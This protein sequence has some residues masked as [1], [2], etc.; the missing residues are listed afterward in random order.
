MN[1]HDY[2]SVNGVQLHYASKG[3]GKLIM[4]LHGFPEFWYMWKNQLDEFGKDYQAVAPDM[5]G[6]NLSSK[7]GELTLYKPKVLMEDIR[8]LAEYLG[9]RKFILVAHD[10]GGA[11]AWSF[12]IFYPQYLEKLVIINAPHP[13]T[14]DRELRN[15]PLQ[16]QASKYMLMFRS[17]QAE[18]KLSENN[19][20]Y[21]INMAFGDLLKRGVMN[22]EDINEYISCWSQPGSLTGGLNYYR[23]SN[24][25]AL[26]Q[27]EKT[28]LTPPVGDTLPVLKVPTL[29]IWGEKDTALLGGCIEGLEKYVINLK[30]KRIPDASHWVVEEK[31][32]L[33]NSYIR[34][35]IE[36]G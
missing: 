36:A 14:F 17:P 27:S 18:Q 30:I 33:V 11:I 21:L 6:Y 24:V 25:G 12:A 5:R 7:P 31:P 16:R 22:E 29:V 20:S 28:L 32:D 2:A 15:N 26:E 9:H 19:Y 34:E 10:W 4:F 23:A 13:A 1:K 8:Q 3:Q 35:F